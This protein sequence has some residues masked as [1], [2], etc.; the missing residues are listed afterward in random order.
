MGS[1][2]GGFYVGSAAGSDT[3][4]ESPEEVAPAAKKSKRS[5]APADDMEDEESLALRLLQGS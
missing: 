2:D 1:D 4:Y 5:Q 3:G